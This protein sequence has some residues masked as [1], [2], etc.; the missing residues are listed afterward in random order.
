MYRVRNG[1]LYHDGKPEI[2]LGQSYYPS[3][4]AQ[5]VPVPPEGDRLGEMALDLREM[6]EAGFNLCRIAAL[7][8]GCLG[9]RR[10]EGGFSPAGRLLPPV[11]RG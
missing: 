1:V 9:E 4:H 6:R 2:A 10:G 7:G 8:G 3:Y 5:K 11:R